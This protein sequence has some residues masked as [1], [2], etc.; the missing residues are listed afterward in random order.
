MPATAIAPPPEPAEVKESSRASAGQA[1]AA[2]ARVI[3]A[4]R[5]PLNPLA[6][7][8]VFNATAK[9]A[10]T[11]GL[12]KISMPS[13]AA[14]LRNQLRVSSPS[15]PAIAIGL[16]ATSTTIAAWRAIISR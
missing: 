15:S 10:A 3:S 2:I 16:V 14:V 9:I 4:E 1:N 7:A 13:Q 11:T 6:V 12:R 8:V 5:I